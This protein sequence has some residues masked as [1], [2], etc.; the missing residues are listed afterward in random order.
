MNR[1]YLR[2]GDGVLTLTTL[3]RSV[4]RARTSS[5]RDGVRTSSTVHGGVVEGL[6]RDC[7]IVVARTVLERVSWIVAVVLVKV[8]LSL[9][10]PPTRSRHPE[11]RSG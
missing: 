4:T 2:Q 3:D 7:E 11:L 5:D 1:R 6:R 8:T 9:P 10:L